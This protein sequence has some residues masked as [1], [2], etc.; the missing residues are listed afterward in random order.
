MSSMALCMLDSAASRRLSSTS[1][2]SATICR[3]ETR[4]W[5]STARPIAIPSFSRSPS[6]RAGASARSA[7]IVSSRRDEVAA[8]DQLRQHHRDGLQRLDLFLVVF[9]EG[10]VLHHQHAEHA[11]AA[12]DRHAGQRVVDLLAGFRAV[13][14]I[15]MRLGVGQ[16]QRPGAAGDIADDAFADREAGL[17]DGFLLRPWV[18]NSSST[19]PARMM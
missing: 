13:R 15:R 2:L 4:G 7:R 6:R 1:G 18:A 5:C 11:A 17:V 16:R 12:Q 3:I 19:S 8:G 9:A 14:E 10:A